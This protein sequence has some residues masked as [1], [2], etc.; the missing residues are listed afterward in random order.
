M[1][2]SKKHLIQRISKGNDVSGVASQKLPSSPLNFQFKS[3]DSSTIPATEVPANIQSSPQLTSQL[4]Q[5]N[6][7][8]NQVNSQL[9][10]PASTSD[11]VAQMMFSRVAMGAGRAAMSAGTKAMPAAKFAGKAAAGFAGAGAALNMADRGTGFAAG[12]MTGDKKKTYQHGI[13]FATSVGSKVFPNIANEINEVGEGAEDAVGK[14]ID[15]QGGY[16]PAF[17]EEKHRVIPESVRNG[18]SVAGVLSGM[19]GGSAAELY[20]KYNILSPAISADNIY[21][22]GMGLAD[23]AESTE[24]NL[25]N[26]QAT[27][28]FDLEARSSYE[29]HKFA[30]EHPEQDALIKG[31]RGAGKPVITSL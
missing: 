24:A 5:E 25:R 18:S 10:L 27:G 8:P 14:A 16:T 31:K 19:L 22:R 26:T 17:D 23:A 12:L 15:S 21:A 20:E 2:D 11:G 13:G 6:Q 1:K 3:L 9:T 29:A 4:K 30:R 7:L 28:Q